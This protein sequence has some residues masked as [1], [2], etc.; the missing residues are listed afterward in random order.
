MQNV[1]ARLVRR[2]GFTLIELLVV[3]AIIAVLVALLLP[4]VQ[5]AREAA[6]R[7][8]CKNNIK[9]IGLAMHNYHDVNKKFPGHATGVTID[10]SMYIALLPQMD[11]QMRFQLMSSPVTYNNQ[12]SAPFAPQ[13][14]GW[15]NAYPPFIGTIQNLVC[16]SDI[17][18]ANAT[19]GAM[20]PCNYRGCVGLSVAYNDTIWWSGNSAQSGVFGEWPFQFGISDISDGTS[21]TIM[22]GE[23]CA[24]NPSN[25]Y[26][27]L[28]NGAL[29]GGFTQP[30]PTPLV[31]MVQNN[32]NPG[33]QACA[34]TVA[35]G[36]YQYTA[37]TNIPTTTIGAWFPGSRW[38]DGRP[39]Y[40][41][42]NTIMPPNGPSC[43]QNFDGGWS[44]MAATSRHGAMVQVGMADGS[45]R[46]IN[47]S[48]N[49]ATWQC[50]GTRAGNDVAGDY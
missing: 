16:P 11:Q 46:Q 28:G 24:G 25:Q 8:Q 33:V 3:I 31:P 45:V 38:A 5:Q 48:I 36:G 34:A 4:A 44:M 22:I 18:L 20:G 2:L 9:Q 14:H 32:T 37:G 7:T 47:Q 49:L 1:V 19:W 23:R 42:F 10:L 17:N 30:D 43:T 21:Q 12:T 26:D 41:T 39:W 50:L 29:V 13:N 6:R 27:V 40:M 35:G 15:D